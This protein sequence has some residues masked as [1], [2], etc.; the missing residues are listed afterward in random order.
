MARC[1]GHWHPLETPVIEKFVCS[2]WLRKEWP[3][4]PPLDEIVAHSQRLAP[5]SETFFRALRHYAQSSTS[6]TILQ[7]AIGDLIAADGVI[8]SAEMSWGSEIDAFFRENAGL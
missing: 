4:D 2:M 6:T 7:R 5:D 8:C 3:G 1:D